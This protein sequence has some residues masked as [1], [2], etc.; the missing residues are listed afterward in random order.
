[1]N[2]EVKKYLSSIGSKGGKARGN[3]KKRGDSNYYKRLALASA[4]KR[5]EKQN[6][7]P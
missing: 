1:M 6:A 4:A 5:K 7:K 2:D 3:P